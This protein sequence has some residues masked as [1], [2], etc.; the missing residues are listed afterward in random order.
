[1]VNF[2][3]IRVFQD[4]FH[5]DQLRGWM[6]TGHLQDSPPHIWWL[7][8]QRLPQMLLNV[9][10][11]NPLTYPPVVKHG[12]PENLSKWTFI[13]RNLHCRWWIFHF[14]VWWPQCMAKRV[15]PVR[16]TLRTWRTTANEPWVLSRVTYRPTLETSAARL[17][18]VTGSNPGYWWICS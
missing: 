12:M 1:M 7:K 15:I 11:A 2:A 5:F 18:A 9:P 14:Y 13:A 6:K 10:W 16:R 17:N 4:S 3:R 8:I